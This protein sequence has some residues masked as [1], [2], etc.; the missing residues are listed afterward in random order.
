M[1]EAANA[2]APGAA[3]G[4]TF[5]VNRN[6]GRG[7]AARIWAQIEPEL[8]RRRPDA[9][10]RFTA[11]PGDATRIARDSAAAVIAVLGG[12]GTINEAANGM[13]G[14]GKTLA[15]IAAGSGNDFIKG[16]GI[17]ADP[18]AALNTALGS[19]RR[20][21]DAAEVATGDPGSLRRR[22]FVNGVGAGF[23]AAVAARV[24]RTRWLG[25]MA[26]YVLSVFRTLG[27]YRAP[28][29]DLAVDGRRYRSHNLLIA[30]G[31]GPCAGGGFYLTPK[32]RVDDGQLDLC[33]V[34]HRSVPEILLLM[35]SVMRG[36]HEG[37][38][39]VTME[40]GKAVEVTADRP[41]HVHADGEVVGEGVTVMR[42]RILEDK[43]TIAVPAS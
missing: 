14:T 4:I 21:V 2:A 32:A 28:L 33:I 37:R 22:I 12:D 20:R 7:R 43:L 42:L 38:S 25:G 8:R 26:V 36:A 30:A 1:P 13:A 35:P 6:A 10:V 29:F 3:D 16:A 41:F 18:A 5:I 27:S 11:G 17:P 40:R 39:G 23:D 31:N 34:T 19:G 9:D 15:V 24:N